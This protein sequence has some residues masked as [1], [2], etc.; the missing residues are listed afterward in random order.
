MSVRECIRCQA[1]KK[2]GNQC[3]RNT[4]KYSTMCFQ[5]TKINKG[6]VVKQS[7][8]P[9][10]GFGLYTTKRIPAKKIIAQYGGE[11]IPTNQYQDSGYGVYLNQNQIIDAKS[12]QSGIARYANMCRAENKRQG[13]CNGN[14]AK[15]SHNRR[16]NTVNLKST[17]VIP[18]GKEIFNSYGRSYFR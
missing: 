11:V 7:N 15:L 2:D 10:S 9:D 5:H 13:Q 3:T 8:I 12:T 16:N 4:C 17:K 1:I 18:A 6:L 14:N